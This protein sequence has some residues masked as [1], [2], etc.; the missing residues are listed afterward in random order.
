MKSICNPFERKPS[1]ENSGDNYGV[2]TI[3]NS[4]LIVV[5]QGMGYD[6][7]KALCLDI[8]T[9]A[10]N[11]YKAEACEEAMRRDIKIS[12]GQILDEQ[13]FINACERNSFST[14]LDMPLLF[15]EKECS[16]VLE[17]L[18]KNKLTIIFG[19]SGTGKTRLAMEVLKQYSSERSCNVKYI[20]NNGENI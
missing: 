2:Q 8:V 4:G 12:T 17:L 9:D 6:N 13:G 7:T 5:N 20:K 10:L 3:S 16:E 1:I 19:Q 18:S 11:K 15:R 14:T